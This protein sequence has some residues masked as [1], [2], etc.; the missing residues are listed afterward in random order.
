MTKG[1]QF[2]GA[3]AKLTEAAISVV[4]FVSPYGTTW[5]SLNVF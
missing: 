2:L 4:M 3:L 1:Q 5:L